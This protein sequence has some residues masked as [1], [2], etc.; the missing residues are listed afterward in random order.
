VA[1]IAAELRW[2]VEHLDRGSWWDADPGDPD[3][4]D[5]DDLRRTA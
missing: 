1:G 3:G 2:A 5:R 4:A